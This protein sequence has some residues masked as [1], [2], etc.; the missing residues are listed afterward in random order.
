MKRMRCVSLFLL[1]LLGAYS[2]AAIGL[3]STGK[4]IEEKKVK[5]IIPGITTKDEIIDIFGK[6][7]KVVDKN[8]GL[9]ELRYEYKEKRIP[10]YLGGLFIYEKGAKEKVINLRVLIK[11]GVVESYHFKMEEEK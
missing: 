8:A 5:K 2:C 11:D 4:S 9:E 7:V 3:D 6:P 1:L 10:L